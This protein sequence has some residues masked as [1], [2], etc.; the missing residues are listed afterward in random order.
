MFSNVHYV[1]S[2]WDFV[3]VE[4]GGGIVHRYLI[5]YNKWISKVYILGKFCFCSTLLKLC[6]KLVCKAI[7]RWFVGNIGRN[8]RINRFC[9]VEPFDNFLL[10]QVWDIQC[11]QNIYIDNTVWN[12][13]P[14]VLTAWVHVSLVS[15]LQRSG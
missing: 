10:S 15:L 2:W 11:L 14:P 6:S 4:G 5:D 9:N 8:T 7:T 13:I 3:C 1:C 12:W